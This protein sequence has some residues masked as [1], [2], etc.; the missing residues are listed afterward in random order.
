MSAAQPSLA[1]AWS[2]PGTLPAL[3]RALKKH[4]TVRLALPLE[5]HH[6]LFRH[7]NPAASRGAPEDFRAEGGPEL[8]ARIA[9]VAGL[10]P[11]AALEDSAR[12]ARYRVSLATPD[13]VVVLSPPERS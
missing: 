6:A 7:L 9:T 4:Q 1:I 10:E 11:L 8:L 2:G 5:M 3:R 13:P 12:V